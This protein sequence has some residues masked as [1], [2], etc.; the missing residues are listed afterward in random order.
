VVIQSDLSK[1]RYT[2]GICHQRYYVGYVSCTLFHK[3]GECCHHHEEEVP[4]DVDPVE[5]S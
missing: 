1:A 4:E 5:P 2:C 3:P